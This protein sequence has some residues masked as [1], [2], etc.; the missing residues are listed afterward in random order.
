MQRLSAPTRTEVEDAH[1]KDDW[2]DI[3]VPSFRNLRFINWW[4]TLGWVL[5]VVSSLP[6]HLFYNSAIFVQISATDY[7]A[8]VVDPSFLSGAP[9]NM[10]KHGYDPFYLEYYDEAALQWLQRN[11]KSLT[12]LSPAE[13]ITAYST[14]VQTARGDVLAVT[15]PSSVAPNGSFYGYQLYTPGAGWVKVHFL[16]N[17]FDTDYGQ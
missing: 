1:M 5:L 14:Q 17:R 4:R 11:T 3:G 9:F 15:E 16:S 12:N 8:Y 7:T 6:L 13:C 2:L 10:S